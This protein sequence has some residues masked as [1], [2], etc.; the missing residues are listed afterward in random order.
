MAVAQRCSMNYSGGAAVAV[1]LCSRKHPVVLY[2]A[3]VALPC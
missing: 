2:M 3:Y 1:L